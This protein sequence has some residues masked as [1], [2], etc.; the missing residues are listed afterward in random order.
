MHGLRH[1]NISL[2]IEQGL[3][4]FLIK[5]I[6]GH[7]RISTTMDTYGHM[8]PE[9]MTARQAMAKVGEQFGSPLLLLS[10]GAASPAPNRPEEWKRTKNDA[11][12]LYACGVQPADIAKQL[13]VSLSSIYNWIRDV[14]SVCARQDGDKEHLLDV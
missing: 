10:A 7:S 5:G 2:L 11:L 9:N 6:V 4:P 8:F 3:D 1:A 13:S 14:P 12:S